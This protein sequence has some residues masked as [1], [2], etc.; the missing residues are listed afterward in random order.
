MY[1]RLLELAKVTIVVPTSF[2]YA[3]RWPG[4]SLRGERDGD[5]APRRVGREVGRVGS[6]VTILC[7]M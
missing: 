4:R 1:V 6:T 3:V 5:K 7:V 2:G